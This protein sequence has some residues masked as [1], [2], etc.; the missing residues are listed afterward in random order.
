MKDIDSKSWLYE[1]VEV[2]K[3]TLKILNLCFWARNKH[4]IHL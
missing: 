1:V 2:D 3:F 4:K